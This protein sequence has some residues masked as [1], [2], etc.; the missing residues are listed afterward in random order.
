MNPYLQL[1]WAR[2]ARSAGLAVFCLSW[3]PAMERGGVT[4]ANRPPRRF[5]F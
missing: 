3:L 2:K 1:L 5:V 4:W